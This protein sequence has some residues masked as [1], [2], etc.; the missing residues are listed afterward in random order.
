MNFDQPGWEKDARGSYRIV[1]NF[2]MTQELFVFTWGDRRGCSKK[3]AKHLNLGF[4][5][6]LSIESSVFLPRMTG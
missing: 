4:L 5:I 6:I 3:V 1:K 2:E